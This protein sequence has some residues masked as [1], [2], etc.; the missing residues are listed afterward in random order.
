MEYTKPWLTYE[1]QANLLQK[2]GLIFDRTELI[3]RLSEVGYY[4]LSGY[5]YVFKQDPNSD[6][7]SFIEGA[8]FSDIW[9]LYTF[10]RR[11]R[12][13]VLDAIERVEVYMRS[14]LAYRLAGVSGPFGFLEHSSLPGIDQARYEH[15]LS[16]FS[17]RHQK[18]DCQR[19]QSTS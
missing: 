13:N 7:E 16:R 1:N 14:Q 19:T 9:D 12:L 4:R 5:W 17:R 11:L 18:G 3:M 15:F 2:R 8:V 10:D 6:D